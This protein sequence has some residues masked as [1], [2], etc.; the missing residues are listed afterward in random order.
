MD[1]LLEDLRR[2]KQQ[3]QSEVG[4][5]FII[6]CNVISFWFSSG[7]ATFKA[8]PTSTFLNQKGLN[9]VIL[10]QA[11]T[12]V[13]PCFQ[14]MTLLALGQYKNTDRCT[15]ESVNK[16]ICSS[17]YDKEIKMEDEPG[18][19]YENTGK[20]NNGV[21][22]TQIS[23]SSYENELK[24]EDDS[25]DC[26]RFE[27]AAPS[28]NE[29]EYAL[30]NNAGMDTQEEATNHFESDFNSSA[31]MEN[32]PKYAGSHYTYSD[33]TRSPGDFERDRMDIQGNGFGAA[34]Y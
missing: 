21:E 14:R 31:L 5:C 33:E 2:K 1:Q 28:P 26:R 27:C 16:Q 34:M 15:L 24:T 8:R 12:N 23:T 4:P 32:V 13:L 7:Y 9:K 3:S 17:S 19:G 11:L 30:G 20:R 10:G 6:S 18:V 22:S 25:M 29:R